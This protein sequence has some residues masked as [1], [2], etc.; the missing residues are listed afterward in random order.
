MNSHFGPPVPPIHLPPAQPG[1]A[2]RVV[3]HVGGPSVDAMRSTDPR[4]AGPGAEDSRFVNQMGRLNLNGGGPFPQPRGGGMPFSPRTDALR[5]LDAT[6]M[7]PFYEGW[8]FY[9]A[10]PQQPGAWPTW[11]RAV[12]HRMRL[13]QEELS[14]L[15]QK[16]ARKSTVGAQ[17]KALGELRQGHVDRLIEQR[18]MEHA[19][20]RFE[21]SCA[22]ADVVE[23]ASKRK[24]ARRGDYETKSMS[25]ILVRK[26][27]PDIPVERMTSA[28]R[29]NSI[30][31]VIDGRY[32][33]GGNPY[34]A[35]PR[36]IEVEPR[37]AN[38]AFG[39]TGPWP[40][41]GAGHPA[42]IPHPTMNL[43]QAAMPP[44]RV[45]Q[46]PQP[47][48]PSQYM[49]IPH[50]AANP[51]PQAP[52][53]QGM[54]QKIP[55]GYPGH[56]HPVIG[57]VPPA[58]GVHPGNGPA[59]EILN[60][61]PRSPAGDAEQLRHAQGAHPAQA[62]FAPMPPQQHPSQRNQHAK[63]ATR[64][65]YPHHRQSRGSIEIVD[66]WLG[67]SSSIED[68][69]SMLFDF[70][71]AS[72]ATEDSAEVNVLVE[73]P[74]YARGSLHHGRGQRSPRQ[75]HREPV[76]RSHSRKQPPKAISDDKAYRSRSGPGPVD[77]V[78][79]ATRTRS[80]RESS[81]ARI[82][83]PPRREPPRGHPAIV[84]HHTR[85]SVDSLD[86]DREPRFDER[87]RE[88]LE[89]NQIRSRDL[90][91][92]EEY[93]RQRERDLDDRARKLDERAD[94]TRY[95]DPPL[96]STLRDSMHHYS[97]RDFRGRDDCYRYY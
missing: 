11:E 22:Y 24:D 21:W 89:I 80:I 5:P 14:K 67:E 93:V 66:E 6:A 61:N 78:P 42:G 3:H 82:T 59:I 8:M 51:M 28:H 95:R 41:T 60:G 65:P 43:P 76:Y 64:Q 17:Y 12:K 48:V 35:G 90:E 13:S 63:Q 86:D 88:R 2:P 85:R 23:Q 31:E 49:N 39:Q 92:R 87:I 75:Y 94:G 58:P 69:D 68:D 46:H 57:V 37:L 50:G 16:Q 97:S 4:F 33:D 53:P 73:K 27:K 7:I 52:M 36:I 83:E 18:M 81:K 9:K 56:H 10:K 15:V 25:V 29:Q 40:G 84:N 32:P 26:L 74:Q 62:P 77:L 72:S 47:H 70:D 44:P 38:N 71:N 96:P 45:H 19:D 30:N 54:P 34:R 55:S 20:P 79:A 1:E 91:K